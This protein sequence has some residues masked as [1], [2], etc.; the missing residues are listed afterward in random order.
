MLQI[1]G[2][3]HIVLRTT[4]L[5]AMLQFYC[6]VLGCSIERSLPEIGLIQLRA[7]MSLID[8]VPVNS[9]LGRLGGKPPNQDGRNLEHF[10]LNLNDINEEQLSHYLS[11]QKID[12]EVPAE[13]Y[14]AAGFSKSVYIKDPEDNVVELKIPAK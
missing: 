7:G 2:I 9:E 4:Q 3:D 6:N 12:H 14:G 11:E 13:R 10:C 1:L 5:D 8:I